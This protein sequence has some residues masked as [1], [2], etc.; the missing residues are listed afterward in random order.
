MEVGSFI[1]D[2]KEH[3]LF[4]RDVRFVT[5]IK[6]KTRVATCR[7]RNPRLTRFA[8]FAMPLTDRTT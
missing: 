4:V 7:A 3:V 6:K 5:H 8:G 2:P 1:K